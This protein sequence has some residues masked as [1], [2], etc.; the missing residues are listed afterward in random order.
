MWKTFASILALSMFAVAGCTKETETAKT[1]GSSKTPAEENTFAL[2]VPIEATNITKGGQAQLQ[3][4]V[5][6]GENLTKAVSLSF[7]PPDGVTIEPESPKIAEEKSEVQFTVK[8]SA[9]AGA[10]EKSI[11][12][13]GKSEGK[14]ASGS[15]K[16]EV[17]EQ[18]E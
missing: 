8:V 5:D 3:I 14:E 4:G 2:E 15:F 7:E 13:T 16:I 12:V 11:P 9:D 17:T 1:P 10:G 6:R 18:T